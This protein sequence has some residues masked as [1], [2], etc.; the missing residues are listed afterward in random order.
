MEGSHSISS[1]LPLPPFFLS[2]FLH[3]SG[4]FEMSAFCFC[5]VEVLGNSAR[6]WRRE[7]ARLREDYGA[8]RAMNVETE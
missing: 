8:K 7:V 4:A 6:K 2:Y 1:S 3:V 5:F